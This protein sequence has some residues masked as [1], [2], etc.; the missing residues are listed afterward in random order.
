MK[1][2]VRAFVAILILLPTLA[3][4]DLSF[5]GQPARDVAAEFDR[6]ARY[7]PANADL[8]LFFDLKP[9]GEI[10]E[11]WTSLRSRLSADLSSEALLTL[12]FGRPA[13]Q[14]SMLGQFK[15]EELGLMDV[16]E[17]PAVS[18]WWN[19]TQYAILK[20]SNEREA[21]EA[22]IHNLGDESA[23]EQKSFEGRRL[24]YGEFLDGS[25]ATMHLAWTIADGL[26]FLIY[27]TSSVWFHKLEALL[28]VP[29]Q[30]TLAAQPAWQLLHSRLP[31]G[32]IAASCTVLAQGAAGSPPPSSGDDPLSA[33][34][35]YLDAVML[36]GVPE[37]EGVRIYID[38]TF[39]PGVADVPAFQSLFAL[40]PVDAAA[41]PSLPAGTALAVMSH[42]AAAVWPW[43]RGL[44]GLEGLG[45]ILGASLLDS[46]LAP[47]GPLSG[48]F[49]LSITPPLPAQPLLG[50]VP[51]LQFLAT[52]PDTDSAQAA[53]LGVAL[54]DSGAILGDSTVE[55]IAIHHQ[56]GTA[57]S[58]YALAYGFDGSTFYLGSSP[59]V[60]GLG[61]TAQRDGSGLVTQPAYQAFLQAVPNRAFYIGYVDG[62]HFLDLVQANTPADQGVDGSLFALASGFD[63]IGI[64]LALTPERLDGVLSLVILE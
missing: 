62:G 60:I 63:G 55:G 64:G 43:V 16:I 12:V 59:E 20:V 18:G 38:G 58:G 14:N 31:E 27:N 11:R 50:S 6:L 35:W 5:G 9:Q 21:R 19:N 3:G 36:A 7:V 44:F 17:G 23:W 26:A 56:V 51:S 28:S 4:C 49:A 29:D 42:D 13:G 25:G 48:A 40:P 41:W 8:P 53:A 22:L 39:A 45:D 2:S 24:Y 10:A 46:L 32:L 15:A 61:L 37:A 47:G 54:K 1:Q 52:S 34:T 57:A 30:D 33:L